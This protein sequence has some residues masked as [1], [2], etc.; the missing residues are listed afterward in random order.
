MAKPVYTK[1]EI[2]DT[3]LRRYSGYVREEFLRQLTGRRGA[4]VFREMRDNDAIVGATMFAVEQILRTVDWKVEPSD[5]TNPQ[6]VEAADFLSSCLDDMD[7]PW[8]EVITEILTFLTFGW[9]LHE[10]VYRYRSPRYGSIYSDGRIGWRKIAL[11][12]QETLLRWKFTE[13]GAPIGFYQQPWSKGGTVF[14]PAEKYVLYR[15]TSNLNN[16]EGRSILRNAYRSWY[17]KKKIEEIEAMGMERDLTGLPVMRVPSQIMR[18]D[19]DAD[20][21]ALFAKLKQ[22]LLNIKRAEDEGIM[23]PTDTDDNGNPLFDLTL[24]TTGG[25]RQFDT[26]QIVTRYDQ[27]IAQ[28]MLADFILLGHQSTGSFA[29]SNDK[30]NIFTVAIDAFLRLIE[31]TTN[32]Q[33]VSRLMQL[34]GYAPELWPRIK[35]GAPEQRSLGE[36]A[37]YV[38]DLV[39]SGAILP[40]PALD[41]HLREIA[42]LPPPSQEE[43]DDALLESLGSSGDDSE[44]PTD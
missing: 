34:N 17:F 8:S 7:R 21:K 30:T 3:G 9:S 5:P 18:D 41:E 25:R 20:E 11:R 27:R 23:L 12:S 32:K 42:D 6:A 4:Q 19:A 10:I 37:S 22:V 40:D 15:T 39:S 44:Q 24:L 29:L 31:D 2:G 14:I 13:H 36:I 16:P 33:A 43:E 35:A 28:S 38:K 26:N 1:I